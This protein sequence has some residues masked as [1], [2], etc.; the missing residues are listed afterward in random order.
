MGSTAEVYSMEQEL[1]AFFETTSATRSGCD[2]RAK[3][4]VGGDVAPIAVQGS[5]SYSVYAGPSDAFV[6]QF[7]PRSLALKMEMTALAQRIYDS[8]IPSVSFHGQVG[9]DFDEREP[10]CV[11]VLSRV[12]GISHLDF[13]LEHGSPENSLEFCTW[14][15]N[16]IGDVARYASFVF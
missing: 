16:L 8:L 10:L 15:E 3:E 13:L 12:S 6:I 7:R 2:A 4:I 9:A 14:R 1:A 11:Y 5:C